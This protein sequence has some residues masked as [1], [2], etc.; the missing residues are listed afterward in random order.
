[1]MKLISQNFVLYRSTESEAQ[2]DEVNNWAGVGP[3]PT[4]FI[5]SGFF[6]PSTW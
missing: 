4:P 3:I 5:L 6:G 2:L 1:M